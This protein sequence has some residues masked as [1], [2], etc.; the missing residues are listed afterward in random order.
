MNFKFFNLN[1]EMSHEVEL[2]KLLTNTGVNI[3]DLM[4]IHLYLGEQKSMEYLTKKGVDILDV[5]PIMNILKGCSYFKLMLLLS[6]IFGMV[7]LIL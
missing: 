4:K 3:N 2:N 6:K 5:L 1:N 7:F